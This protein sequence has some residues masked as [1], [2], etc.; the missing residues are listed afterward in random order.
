MNTDRVRCRQLGLFEELMKHGGV[1]SERSILNDLDRTSESPLFSGVERRGQRLMFHV[2]KCVAL[3]DPELGYCQGMN[4]IAA[5]FLEVVCYSRDRRSN[6]V[7]RSAGEMKKKDTK[8][9]Q[10]VP[11]APKARPLPP[12]PK[13]KDV[14][15]RSLPRRPLPPP[16]TTRTFSPKGNFKTPPRLSARVKS[17]LRRSRDRS[18]STSS[19][20][21]NSSPSGKANLSGSRQGWLYLTRAPTVP[22]GIPFQSSESR[23]WFVFQESRV[24]WYVQSRFEHEAHN[25]TS[26]EKK[27]NHHH[28]HHNI[29]FSFILKNTN[30]TSFT[31]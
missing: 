26:T 21:S 8:E 30:S 25:V 31:C 15:T 16:P 4:W 29:H 28:H 6:N 9:S 7:D 3:R 13:S 2:L 5:S 12:K 27:H 11:L 18:I 22:F 20:L 10:I 1:P 14:V 17:S 19:S 24:S 23:Y